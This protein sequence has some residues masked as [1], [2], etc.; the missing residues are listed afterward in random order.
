LA[1]LAIQTSSL[2]WSYSC[3]SRPAPRRRIVSVIPSS[4]S[5]GHVNPLSHSPAALW[6]RSNKSM[7][8]SILIL[9]KDQVVVLHGLDDALDALFTQFLGEGFGHHAE[10][11]LR[12]A[13]AQ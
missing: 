2:G 7:I 3:G 5:Q 9:L 12:S 11:G 6:K 8:F 1:D 13:L 10:H 4:A